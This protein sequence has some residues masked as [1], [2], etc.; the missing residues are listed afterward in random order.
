[1]IGVAAACC[2]IGTATFASGKIT[3]T[4]GGGRATPEYNSFADIDKAE[5]EVGYQVQAVE[6][7]SNDYQFFDMGIDHSTALDDDE[8][9]VGNWDGITIT[10]QKDG[11]SD[12]NLSI[13]KSLG[14][15]SDREPDA[16]AQ[17][18]EVT[19]SYREDIYKSVPEDYELTEEDNANMEKDNYYISYGSDTVEIN[20]VNSVYWVKDGITYG[21]FGFDLGMS[22]DEMFSMAEEIINQ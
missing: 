2:L 9:E 10:Y 18:G 17:V 22:S 12:V 5:K 21:L 4:I 7:F 13:E 14:E 11:A 16:T 1:M 6:S 19:L 20:Q 8:N 15:I 3:S